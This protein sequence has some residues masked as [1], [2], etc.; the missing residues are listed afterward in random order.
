MKLLIAER[1]GARTIRSERVAF[2]QVLKGSDV[3]TLHCPLTD[4]TK[5]LIDRMS[6]K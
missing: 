5:N 2:D 6:F 4:E 1:K 3:I